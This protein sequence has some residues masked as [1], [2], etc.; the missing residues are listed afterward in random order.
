MAEIRTIGQNYETWFLGQGIV[1]FINA[2]GAAFL[3][4]PM[5]LSQGGT[6]ADAG[7]IVGLLPFV[8]LLSPVFGNIAD[9]FRL[10]REMVLAGLVALVLA[11]I[12]MSF[13]EQELTYVVGALLFGTGGGLIVVANL[14]MLAGSGLDEDVMAKRMG[15]L[16]MSLPF[17]QFTAL[18]ISAA[19]LALGVEVQTLFLLHAGV[20]AVGFVVMWPLTR[21]PAER[22]AEQIDAADERAAAAPSGST[23]RLGFAAIVFS[24]FGLFL[25]INFLSQFGEQ[26]VE[27]QYPNYLGDVFEI[28]PDIAAVAMAVAVLISAPLYPVSGRWAAKR[29]PKAPFMV[30]MAVRTLTVA[31][32]AFI[33]I[34]VGDASSG[35]TAGWLANQ[36]GYD[37]LAWVAMGLGALAFVLGFFLKIERPTDTEPEHPGDDAVARAAV[38]AMAASTGR[39][40]VPQQLPHTQGEAG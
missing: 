1:G 8:A 21:A 36:A 23:R 6:P 3:V 4:A 32:L 19:L 14:G 40:G 16:Q 20:A 5:I 38:A 28:E 39:G 7:M 34:E 37:T 2:G 30:S 9:R 27:S 25:L 12:T 13:A 18:G 10:H 33:S 31:G 17:G 26:I 22:V 15:L 29:G 24:G 35:F 11:S